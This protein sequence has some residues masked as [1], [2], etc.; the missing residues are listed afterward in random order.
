MTFLALMDLEK[1]YNRADRETMRQVLEMN[2]VKRNDLTGMRSFYERMSASVRVAGHVI[3]CFSV[4]N[5]LTLR[6]RTSAI[7]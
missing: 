6:L 5:G 4:N 2:R 3:G 1:T 7:L